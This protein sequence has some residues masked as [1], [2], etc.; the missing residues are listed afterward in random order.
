[1]GYETEIIMGKQQLNNI[2]LSQEQEAFI[3]AALDGKNILVDACIGSGKTT[4]IQ[5]FCDLVSSDTRVLYLT[6]NRLLKMD[7]RNRIKNK[8]VTVTNYHGFA[9]SRLKAAN[10]TAGMQDMIQEFLNN[11]I[12][13]PHYDILLIDEY[14]DI[15]QEFADELLVIKKWNPEIQIIAVGDMEQKIYD[16]TTLDVQ[17]FIH[18]FLGDYL[19]LSFTK[20]FRL[21]EE[22]AARLGRIWDKPI[23]GVNE[24]CIVE[25]MS[26]DEVCEFLSK[27]R[28]KDVLCLGSRNGTM[29]G[30][31]NWMEDSYPDVWNKKTVY[32]SIQ[33]GDK[34]GVTAPNSRT[35]IFTTFD[36]S[37]G[38]ERKICVV[39]DYTESYWSVRIDQPQQKYE[40]LRNI[41]CVA[42]SRGKEHIIFVNNNDAMLSEETLKTNVVSDKGFG[43]LDISE[44]FDFKYVED[45]EAC[46][47]LLD[48]NEIEE[49]DHTTINVKNRDEMI[50]LSPCIGIYQEA[51]YFDGYDI[52]EAIL[53]YYRIHDPS[54]MPKKETLDKLSVEEKVLWLTSLETKQKRY[55]N[56]VELPL[57]DSWSEW[58]LKHRLSTEFEAG[59]T[60]QKACEL[61]FSGR[62]NGEIAVHAIGVL[63]VLKNDVVYELKFVSELQHTHFLQCA[64]YMVALGLVK[65]ILWNTRDNKKYDIAVP[66]KEAFLD[67]VIKTVTKGAITKYYRPGAGI[68]VESRKKVLEDEALI[69]DSGKIA[70]IDTE[71][72]Y[73]DKVMSIG[74]VIADGKSFKVLD[75]RYI[76]IE[77][78]AKHGGLFSN[79]LYKTKKKPILC[80]RDEAIDDLKKWL[81]NNHI[82]Q[83]YA[84]NAHFDCSHLPELSCY[85]WFDIMRLASNN[86]YNQFI[87][88][89]APVYKT[90]RLKSGFGVEPIYRMV[91]G[92]ESYCEKHNALED[93]KDELTIMKKLKLPMLYYE[94]E[95]CI[96]SGGQELPSRGSKRKSKAGK[97]PI[98]QVAFSVGMHVKYPRLGIG[99]I[100]EVIEGPFAQIL[101]IEF[102]SGV[103]TAMSND[104]GLEVIP[105]S[106]T[107]VAANPKK[108][109][110]FKAKPTTPKADTFADRKAKYEAKVY[111]RSNHSIEVLEYTGSKEKVTVKCKLCNYEWNPRAD[112]LLA[113]CVCP[114]CKKEND[115]SLNEK[116]FIDKIHYLSRGG[117]LVTGYNTIDDY[118][119]AECRTC[120]NTWWPKAYALYQNCE[121]PYCK[122]KKQPIKV[123]VKVKRKKG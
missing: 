122:V 42:A 36:S 58:Q 38:M 84:Y 68:R 15:E 6:Y 117:I 31:L 108:A 13:V 114:R 65:G 121:C 50:D 17:P 7:A 104:L 12:S 11:E 55:R 32:A 64:C 66:N 60:V 106:S 21:S 23:V 98:E 111:E 1:M 51:F 72:N 82:S 74:V 107:D 93:A 35:A 25:E 94:K 77:D 90:G 8:N 43:L 53:H 37:K 76:I 59:E 92:K 105:E 40:I 97:I 56:Q 33:D 89:D 44:L 79:A 63:D 112:H 27:Q 99:T 73:G 85:D 91:T 30:V 26:V 109:T 81:E 80:N 116:W 39:F 61:T 16:K 95:A 18:E 4:A 2:V 20:C 101:R 49:K 57:V 52:D 48:V 10:L 123:K 3:K 45:V 75:E 62:E 83:I 41:F 54:K 29:S 14:Q 115:T 70:V 9:Y 113:R 69:S 19:P 100:T 110:A 34:L 78:E 67:A 22:L 47:S 120:G 86:H 88:D 28:P 87:P 5:F 24:N 119:T 103:K 46:Y 71:T 102:L 118:V 96:C